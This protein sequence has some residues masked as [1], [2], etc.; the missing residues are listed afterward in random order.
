MLRGE[1]ARA[2]RE[3]EREREEAEK[4]GDGMCAR[5]IEVQR[6]QDRVREIVRQR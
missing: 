4:E 5:E 3:R 1:R 2:K 6:N